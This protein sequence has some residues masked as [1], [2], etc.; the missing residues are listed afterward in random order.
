MRVLTAAEMKAA[1]QAAFSRLGLP[2]RV[3]MENAG[4]EVCSFLFNAFGDELPKGTLVLAGT[5]NNGG[6]GFVIARTLLNRGLYAEVVLL[7]PRDKLKDEALENLE[8]FL[9]SSG[10]LSEADE[11]GWREVE[12]LQQL[13]EFGLIVD[14]I[15][16]TGFHGEI[17]GFAADVIDYLNEE[18]DNASIPVVSVDLP[19]GVDADQG[20]VSGPAVLADATVAL[21]CLKPAHLLFPSSSFCGEIH[22]AD[23]GIPAGI[24]EISGIEREL[25]TEDLAA[26]L[27]QENIR[28]TPEEHKGTRGHVL[29]IGGSSGRLGAV[30][31][32]AEAALVCGAGLVTMLMPKSAA[33]LIA[34]TLQ[35]LMCTSLD[36]DKSGSFSG[37]VKRLRSAAEGKDALVIGP[38]L[39]QCEGTVKVLRAALELCAEENLPLVV[40]ADALNLLA[41][42]EELRA[43]LG[44]QMILTPHPGEMSRLCRRPVEEVQSDRMGTAARLAEEWRCFV[45]LKGA[46]TIIAGPDGEVYVNPAAVPTLATAGAGDVLSGV[47]GA[48]LAR[49]FGPAA[50]AVSAVF[51]HGCAGEIGAIEQGGVFGTTAGSLFPLLPQV[52]NGLLTLEQAELGL[53]SGRILPGSMTALLETLAPEHT[54]SCGSE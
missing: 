20:E 37:D 14:A 34:P 23:I 9:K 43:S 6:D 29:V 33:D 31:M 18:A 13:R 46:R 47:I 54:C 30:R 45:I 3:V 21:Q 25:I 16:G 52:I 39:G 50:A 32:S 38:G 19:S 41:E 17:K 4:R 26:A 42:H 5:G 7:G 2:A 36:S 49:G 15:Y 12:A 40:D 24:E 53:T 22:V 8:T 11:N 48:F 35:E 44:P 1:D 27:L 51:V 10:K 28:I